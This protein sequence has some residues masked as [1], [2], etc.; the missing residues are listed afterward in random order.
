M[1]GSCPFS[2]RQ[3]DGRGSSCMRKSIG[4]VGVQIAQDI[5]IPFTLGIYPAKDLCIIWEF[6]F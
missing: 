3:I 4:H 6:Y 5:L 1:F 2:A